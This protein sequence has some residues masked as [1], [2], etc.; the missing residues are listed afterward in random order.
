L[1]LVPGKDGSMSLR[2]T[3]FRPAALT[4]L[5]P[6]LAFLADFDLPVSVTATVAFNPS[7]QLGKLRAELRLGQGQVRIGRGTIS[8]ASGT[9]GLSGTPD[10]VVISQGHVNLS[11]QSASVAQT[12]S[13]SGTVTRITDRLLASLTVGVEHIDV[14]SIPGLWPVGVGDEALRL[15]SS[16]PTR[17]CMRSN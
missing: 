2:L 16:K 8:L 11:G 17:R 12:V 15:S 6:D 7:L 14:A 5:P 10:A 13:F 9:I 1:D 4:M 3:P